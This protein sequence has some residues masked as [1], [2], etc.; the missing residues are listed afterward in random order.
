MF[1]L[2]TGQSYLRNYFYSQAHSLDNIAII[3]NEILSKHLR[4]SQCRQIL[5]SYIVDKA[6]I[7]GVKHP[8]HPEITTIKPCSTF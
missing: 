6:G 3:N 2:N 5:L 1:L 8:K 7:D 4:Y